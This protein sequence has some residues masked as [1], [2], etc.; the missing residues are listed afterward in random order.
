M[1]TIME[2]AERFLT[3]RSFCKTYEKKLQS[4]I[5][6]GKRTNKSLTWDNL[7]EWIQVGAN[8]QTKKTK[9]IRKGDIIKYNISLQ[10]QR[11]RRLVK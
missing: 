9:D 4:L 2:A 3:T 10:R 1:I 5:I 6:Y 8:P 11:S 7:M